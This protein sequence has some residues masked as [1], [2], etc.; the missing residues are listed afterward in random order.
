MEGIITFIVIII[1]F[2]LLNR[3][4]GA[5]KRTQQASTRRRRPYAA[6]QSRP[7]RSAGRTVEEPAFFRSIGRR[8]RRDAPTGYEEEEAEQEWEE[9]E[10]EA[11]VGPV[12]TRKVKKSS[13]QAPAPNGLRKILQDK[14][15]LV[16]A[17]IFHEAISGPPAS[18]G[19]RKSLFTRLR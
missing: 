16:A 19:K 15:S 11:A 12:I 5:A 2:N 6:E 17:F 14:D 10:P 4:L 18:R 3:F 1:I 13:A 9:E 7:A 8:D